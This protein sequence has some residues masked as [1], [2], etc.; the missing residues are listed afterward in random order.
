M[1]ITPLTVVEAACLCFIVIVIWVMTN[2]D[3]IVAGDNKKDDG[4]HPI[5]GGGGRLLVFHLL[6]ATSF[7]V[8]LVDHDPP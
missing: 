3:H 7:K 4:I 2:G 1:A 8:P 5:D 6:A